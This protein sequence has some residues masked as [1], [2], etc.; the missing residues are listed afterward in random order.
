VAHHGS[1]TS[2]SDGFLARTRARV[3]VV[4]AGRGNRFGHPHR[5]VVA[6][7]RAHGAVVLGTQ[8]CGELSVKVAQGGAIEMWGQPGCGGQ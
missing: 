1:R 3:A 6:K 2:S 8:G 5:E 7:H 4:Q